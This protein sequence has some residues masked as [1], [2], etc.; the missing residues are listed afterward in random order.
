LTAAISLP[1]DTTMAALAERAGVGPASLYRY[2]PD[3]GAVYAELARLAQRQ[4]LEMVKIITADTE[5][6]TEQ[7]IELMCRLAIALPRHLRRKVDLDVP[8]AWSEQHAIPIFNE[9]I[10]V[11]TA[12]LRSRLPSPPDDLRRRVFLMF[13]YNR[14][15]IIFSAMMPDGS[16]EDEDAVRFMVAHATGLLGLGVDAPAPGETDDF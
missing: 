8:F 4:F 12:W 7:G 1:G 14:G 3:L 10:D 15:I 2:F 11:I 5:L 9:A 6:A 16:P 13:A